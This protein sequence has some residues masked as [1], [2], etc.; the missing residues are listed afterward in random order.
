MGRLV[1]G[2]VDGGDRRRRRSRPWPEER[3]GGPDRL[4]PARAGRH[5]EPE[6]HRLRRRRDV[7][8]MRG[9]R[10][11]H[12]LPRVHVRRAR[13]RSTRTSRPT[14]ARRT[15]TT[16]RRTPR[17]TLAGAARAP[18]PWQRPYG[19][20]NPMGVS[21]A[22]LYPDPGRVPGAARS[23]R[24]ALRVALRRADDLDRRSRAAPQPPDLPRWWGY[25]VGRWEGDTL[26]VGRG[27]RRADLGGLFRV[28]TAT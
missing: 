16:P 25:S 23:D 19:T 15:A 8:G 6:R 3:G 5:L 9:S 24:P 22:L 12:G 11:Q 17:S 2:V 4:Q 13:S 7:P 28:P 20:C 21:R 27:P 10:L 18:G 1:S 14:G 26:V